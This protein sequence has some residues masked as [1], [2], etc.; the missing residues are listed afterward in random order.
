MTRISSNR[1]WTLL[2]GVI[3]LAGCGSDSKLAPHGTASHDAGF[4]PSG[5]ELDEDD[6]DDDDDDDWTFLR[7][8]Q[9]APSL[10]R[11]TASFWAVRGKTRS[12]SIMYSAR[13]G[14][15]DSTEF[16]RFVVASGSL[17][18]EPDGTPVAEGDSVLITLTVV[19]TDS[20]IVDFQPQG[21]RFAPGAP[22][23]LTFGYAET[24]P[25]L[26]FDGT[27]DDDD[28]KLD[29][30]LTIGRQELPSDPF[31]SVPSQVN[32]APDKVQADIDGFTRYAVMY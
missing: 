26:D 21:L 24:D 29:A 31:E 25:D 7:P 32:T 27:L 16:V 19:D 30:T 9:G 20:L 3:L 2:A 4:E 28:A 12:G 17:Y 1:L 11:T 18:Q 10:A 23:L 14:A 13:P 22:A 8:A 15:T 6:V 5:P